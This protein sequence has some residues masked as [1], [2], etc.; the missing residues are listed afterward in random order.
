MCE[1]CG[2]TPGYCSEVTRHSVE[3]AAETPRH[4]DW[5]QSTLLAGIPSESH[6]GRLQELC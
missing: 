2:V 1:S 3:L 4:P 6:V 5:C